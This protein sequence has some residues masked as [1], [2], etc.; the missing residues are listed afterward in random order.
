MKEYTSFQFGWFILILGPMM[1]WI[2]YLY[3]TQAG[4]NPLPFVPMLLVE[5]LFI[6][7]ILLFYGLKVTVKKEEI[8]L[9]Y[10]IGWIHK[11]I[12]LNDVQSVKTV[13]NPW[14]Y[15][16]GIRVIPK[17]M[18]YNIHGLDAVELTFSS[19]KR[20]VRIGSPESHRLKLEIERRLQ[21]L[22]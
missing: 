5:A 4:D 13:R 11:T 21:A 22:R 17:R 3:A 14:Y 19:K 12:A 16:L 1:I 2:Y 10:G 7:I 18:L 6:V 20:I 9:K 15:G 8:E